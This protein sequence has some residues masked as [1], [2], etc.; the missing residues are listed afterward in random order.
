MEGDQFILIPK[1]KNEKKIDILASTSQ[2]NI[3]IN[4]FKMN[5]ITHASSQQIIPKHNRGNEWCNMGKNWE[6]GVSLPKKYFLI[7]FSY[8]QKTWKIPYMLISGGERNRDQMKRKEKENNILWQNAIKRKSN[9]SHTQPK[10]WEIKNQTTSA[11]TNIEINIFQMNFIMH[12]SSKQIIP[13]H[14]KDN[15]QCD[16]GEN[17]EYEVYLRS[18]SSYTSLAPEKPEKSTYMLLNGGQR[19]WDQLK[20]REKENN[21]P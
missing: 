8:S 15:E 10:K 12:I 7:H 16:M 1:K 13:K 14:N 6:Y 21:I 3:E 9:S 17:R 19:N 4:E 20:R 2:R 11:Q 18:I 5:S